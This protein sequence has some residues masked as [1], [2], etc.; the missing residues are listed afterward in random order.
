MSLHW[1]SSLLRFGDRLLRGVHR[2]GRLRLLRL[3]LLDLQLLLLGLT[4]L[5]LL[6]GFLVHILKAIL[7]E[8]RHAVLVSICIFAT[9]C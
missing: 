6:S 4:E 3:L 2:D 9:I 8:L 7:I 5:C 1:C